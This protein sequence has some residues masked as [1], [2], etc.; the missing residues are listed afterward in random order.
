M[1]IHITG[2]QLETGDALQAHVE[3]RLHDAVT[4]YFERAGDINVTFSKQGHQF[5]AA[6]ALHLDSGLYLHASGADSDIYACFDQSVG[7]I[8]K[9]LRRYKR[10]LKNHHDQK[11]ID[12][13]L[14]AAER[15]LAP[16][17]EDNVPAEFTPIV[18]AESKKQVARLSVSEA[19][20]QLELGEDDFV[21]FKSTARDALSLIYKR[22]D[23]NIGW[24]ELDAYK[25]K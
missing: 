8:E 16:E 10:R 1:K 6:C 19:V 7:K 9:Q 22:R 23:G 18:V 4:K 24:L 12:A 17:P 21:L 11:R 20:M 13:S 3:N 15:V 2:R 5:Q 14:M 25:A